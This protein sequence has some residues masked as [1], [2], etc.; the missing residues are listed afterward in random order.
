[1]LFLKY[2]NELPLIPIV[3]PWKNSE[4]VRLNFLQAYFSR[5]FTYNFLIIIWLIWYFLG[6]MS[7]TNCITINEKIGCSAAIWH[8]NIKEPIQYLTSF[9]SAPFFYN[10]SQHIRFTTI[11]FLI[12]V[13]SF[14]AIVG[15]KNTILVFFSTIVSIALLGGLVSNFGF[16]LFPHL[17]IFSYMLER[18]WMGASSGF[19]GII[20]SMSHLSKFKF[21]L[22]GTVIVFESWNFFINEISFSISI[23][24]IFSCLFGY[25][26]WKQIMKGNT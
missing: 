9:F 14:E 16:F 17:E 20:G 26:F 2:N 1:M 25:F 21:V 7:S 15:T 8:E 12:F 19:M 11:S 24:H 23:T 10:S 5:F 6:E 22:P 13:Q 4:G 18:N 3:L